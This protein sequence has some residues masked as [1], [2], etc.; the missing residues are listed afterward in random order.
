MTYL[1]AKVPFIMMVVGVI[2]FLAAVFLVL[3]VLV[4][5]GKGGGLGAAF[6]GAG[7][8]SLMGT[9]TGDFLTWV[10][11]GVTVVF[12]FVGVLMSKFYRPTDLAGLRE[13]QTDMSEVDTSTL[14]EDEQLEE[15]NG[16]N[17]SE[18]AKTE[19]VEEDVAEEPDTE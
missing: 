1:L 13:E 19:D 11:I 3:I 10:T 14:V 6:G 8:N 12:L 16:E 9:K 4:Q 17:G 5:K 18:P 7:S 15:N 2:W